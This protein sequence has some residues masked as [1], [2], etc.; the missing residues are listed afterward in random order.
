M[1][2]VHNYFY[3]ATKYV[4]TLYS[5]QFLDPYIRTVFHDILVISSLQFVEFFLTAALNDSTLA[6]GTITML[7]YLLWKLKSTK[8]E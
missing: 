3:I 8:A 6:P 1:T 4:L 2:V 5:A 7:I